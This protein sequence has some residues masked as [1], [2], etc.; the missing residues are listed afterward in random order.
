MSSDPSFCVSVVVKSIELSSHQLTSGN[1]VLLDFSPSQPSFV[2]SSEISTCIESWN[3]VNLTSSKSRPLIP[4]RRLSQTCLGVSVSDSV[5]ALQNTIVQ[6]HNIGGSFHFQNNS[7]S[8]SISKPWTS[9][10]V[11]ITSAFPDIITKELQFFTPPYTFK[12][13]DFIQAQSHSYWSLSTLHE[14]VTPTHFNYATAANPVTYIDCSFTQMTEEEY[15]PYT[16][17][18]YGGSAIRHHSQ[19]PLSITN[20]TFTECKTQFGDGG[21]ILVMTRDYEAFTTLAIEGSKFVGCTCVNSGGA[22]STSSFGSHSI[23]RSSFTSCQADR[24]GG[25]A[26]ITPCVVSF[27]EFVSNTALIMGGGV[28]TGTS[29]SLLF[30][31][32][33]GNTAV[34][35]PD[36]KINVPLN[37]VSVA[38]GCTQS[39]DF[40]VTDDVLFVASG[41]EGE[42]CSFSSPCSSLSTALQ[43]VGPS[44]SK[45]IKLGTG[46][47]GEVHIVASSSPT[48]YG[49]YPRDEWDSTE[50]SSSFSLILDNSGTV[51]LTY[52]DL[53]PLSGAAIVKST[54]D[55][56]VSLNNLKMVEVDGISSAPFVFSAGTASFERCHFDSLSSMKCSLISIS[57]TAVVVI[58]MSLFHQIESS[59]SVVSVVDGSLTLSSV[60]FR[61]L[62]RTSGLGGAALDCEGAAALNISAQFSS[63]HSKTGLCGAIHLNVTDLSD[64]TFS[65]T[66][67]YLNR[68]RD[69]SVAHDIHLSTI[70]VD[71]FSKFEKS[72]SS[73]SHSP[74]V[75]DGTGKSGSFRLPSQFDVYDDSQLYRQV[76]FCNIS[77]TTSD[78]EALDLSA[79]IVENTSFD[80][81]LYNT[82]EEMTS[83]RPI[84]KSGGDLTIRSEE[85]SHCSPLTQSSQTDGTLFSMQSSSTF[86]ITSCILILSTKQTDP[87]ITLDSSS[88]LYVSQSILSSDGGLSNRAFC[89]SEGSISLQNTSV[90]SMVFAT[91]SCF[92]TRGGSFKFTTVY[93][94]P[95]CCVT[96]LTTSGNG[97][98]LNAKDTIV[99]FDAVPMTDCH[100]A[101][102]GAIFV[103]NCSFSASSTQFFR[104]SAT[105][106]GGAVCVENQNIQD[107]HVSI[108]L[109]HIV[110]CSADLGGGL[111]VCSEVSTSVTIGASD[112][113]MFQSDFYFAAF[114]GCKARKG[115]GAYIDGDATTGQFS[116]EAEKYFN[117]SFA[118]GSD[119][120]FSKRFADTHPDLEQYLSNLC[121]NLFSLSG[122]SFDEDGQ[123][124]HVEV[125]G[126]PQLSRNLLPPTMEVNEDSS[127][128]PPPAMY[129]SRLY[130]NSLSYYLPFIEDLAER[131]R[132]S[133]INL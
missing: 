61:H 58:R 128:Y 5:G 99:S 80:F 133:E 27:C 7:I 87:M 131:R 98:L 112:W 13:E 109:T 44:E 6:D 83:F 34:Q 50:T 86:T 129:G 84:E 59:S 93:D 88:T 75:V 97:A 92:E 29:V 118:E 79:V 94:C 43:K 32:F 69:E 41:A 73:L 54:V 66:L 81:T 21:A 130:F 35:Y 42:D 90:V 52:L 62:T 117:N 53:V 15:D 46:S 36:W 14:L 38:F 102:G 123:Y 1:S 60:V 82:R 33:E 85:Y 26:S 119:L 22:L 10:D 111:Y 25:A 100:A 23:T 70:T 11:Y 78:V 107:L 89:R 16:N 45:E 108:S 106:K 104:C 24:F 127:H 65:K 56:S 110:D 51:T 8:S 40:K 124:R 114:S 67:F 49:Y 37:S 55:V 31:H 125:E 115:S 9:K 116:F 74:H 4:A 91:H 105:S 47:F 132:V 77:L 120:F 39:S 12:G 121:G 17:F 96:N 72:L 103:Q 18:K 76:Q 19:A 113:N 68:G 20:C 30:C 2:E 122:R 95:I 101:N 3:V 57:D 64:V 48:I 71:D 126:Y 63:C 28:D